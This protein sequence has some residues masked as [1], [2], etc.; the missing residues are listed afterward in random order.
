MN[1]H[2]PNLDPTFYGLVHDEISK[3]LCRVGI[4]EGISPS[5]PEVLNLIKCNCSPNKPCSS[6][7]CTCVFSKM[8]CSAM[9][10]CRGDTKLC[11]S[12]ETKLVDDLP[13]DD[14]D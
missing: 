3:I 6:K 7:R 1:P 2:P 10:Q 11:F 5:P 8:A 12:K 4:P 9:C 14:E 13:A